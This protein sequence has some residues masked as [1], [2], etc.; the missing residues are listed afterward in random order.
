MD[1]RTLGEGRYELLDQIGQGGMA[2]VWRAIDTRL[3]VERAIKILT[4]RTQ[5]TQTAQT[6]FDREAR[7][8]ARLEH[9]HIV[10]VHDVGTEGN[11]I[12][13]V[14]SLLRGGT[15]ADHLERCGP[16]PPR[17]ACTVV[18]GVLRALVAA[19][20]N[21]VI[22]RDVK[23]QNILIDDH[24]VPRLTDFGIARVVQEDGV[25]TRTGAVMGTYAFMAPEQRSNAREADPRSDIYAVGA[26]LVMLLTAQ[27]PYDL[28]HPDAF[29]AQTALIPELLRAWVHQAT[30]FDPVERQ[31]SAGEALAQLQALVAQLPPDPEDASPLQPLLQHI[32]PQ[33]TLYTGSSTTHDGVRPAPVQ[34]KSPRPVV[35]RSRP[36]LAYTL[37]GMILSGTV[38]IGLVAAVALVV[39]L[40]GVLSGAKAPS[41]ESA[42][43]E[44]SGEQLA[45]E[46]PALAP[47]PLDTQPTE[48][49]KHDTPADPPPPA[50]T[51]RSPTRATLPQTA[52][53]ERPA[54]SEPPQ[55]IEPVPP[56][57]P[58]L[59]V[60]VAADP[61]A[62]LAID[63]LVVGTTPWSGPLS[64]GEHKLR[65]LDE[66]G[67][68]VL[69]RPIEVASG[70][71]LEYCWVL[72]TE[73]PCSR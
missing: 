21:G 25:L 73:E 31:P 44:P 24:G 57:L 19:H 36:W 11:Q 10:P 28:H 51:D 1:R 39:G 48:L 16:M 70:K 18:D 52:S 5:G 15:A 71:R 72:A 27:I 58:T 29:A 69:Q 12:Y 3:G 35:A 6:R 54:P 30:R 7:L 33:N 53:G 14:M 34:T 60:R 55:P 40:S 42:E 68:P 50:Q 26:L 41:A 49:P 47:A 32:F 56:P 17:Q 46:T 4:P 38:T 22:H 13:M 43:G 9:P 8:M 59:V 23:P 65:F 66:T 62:T 64:L 67:S 45:Q 63:G 37:G 20:A 2:S 61:S